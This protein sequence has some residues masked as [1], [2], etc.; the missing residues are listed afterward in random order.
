MSA[1]TDVQLHPWYISF[2]SLSQAF[3]MATSLQLIS[4]SPAESPGALHPGCVHHVTTKGENTWDVREH[5]DPLIPQLEANPAHSTSMGSDLPFL[6]G[7]LSPSS[8][9]PA[10]KVLPLNWSGMR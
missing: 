10:A 7:Y 2:N 9:S 1:D 3:W 5:R 4:A 6:L 8:A